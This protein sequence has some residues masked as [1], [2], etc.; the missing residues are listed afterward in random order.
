MHQVVDPTNLSM[1]AVQ[2]CNLIGQVGLDEI[3][4]GSSVEFF[5]AFSPVDKGI[6][7]ILAR[8]F[9]GRVPLVAWCAVRGSA[10]IEGGVRRLSHRPIGERRCLTPAVYVKNVTQFVNGGVGLGHDC[11]V[12]LAQELMALS[13]TSHG[14]RR[15]DKHLRVEFGI[16]FCKWVVFVRSKLIG[17][18]HSECAQVLEF[19]Y[20][21]DLMF[22]L[23]HIIWLPQRF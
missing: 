16:L 17:W 21:L 12:A 5:F 9:D 13:L 19:V 23:L 18:L 22:V 11:C 7:K 8:H 4:P 2:A 6:S 1:H 15:V 3:G 14:T 10:F 20:S